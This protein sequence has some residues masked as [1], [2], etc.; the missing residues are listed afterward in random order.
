MPSAPEFRNGGG[1]I[2]CVEIAHELNPE[3]PGRARC[4]H[5][6]AAEVAVYLKGEENRRRNEIPPA[7]V[8]ILLP[9]A[10]YGVN[11]YAQPVGQNELEKIAPQHQKQ[12]VSEIGKFQ[13]LRHGKLLQKILGPLNRPCDELRKERHEKRI[14]KEILL[15]VYVAAVHVDGVAQRLKGVE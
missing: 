7:G 1:E 12:A 2:R 15:R 14:A 10:V 6:V 13:L 9:A 5:G 8:D 3:K 11:V 4:Y